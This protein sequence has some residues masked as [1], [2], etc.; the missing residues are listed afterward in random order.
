MTDT[1][2]GPVSPARLNYLVY[3]TLGG[4]LSRVPEPLAE[5]SASLVAEALAHLPAGSADMYARHLHRVLGRDL[6][7]AE[8]RTWTRRAYRAYARYWLEGARLGSLDRRVIERRMH[9]ES[10]WAQFVSAMDAGRGVILAL[11]HVGSWEWGGAW[12]ALKGY[13]MTAVAEP[14]EPPEL[15]DWF[16]HERE[17]M[18]LTIVQLGPDVGPVLLRTLRGGGLVGLL[19]DRDIQGNGIEVEFFGERTTLPA[20]PATLA[21]R[22][23]AALIPAAVYSG[24]G[25]GHTGVIGA[26]V[27]LE[28]TGRLRADVARITQDVAKALERLIRRAPEQWHLFQPNWPSDPGYGANFQAATEESP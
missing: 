11:P 16:V 28:R 2:A 8:L 9:V 22:T 13:P 10:G 23:G 4:V 12:L 25:S 18:G 14:I 7:R 20:G 3:R 19:C 21:L 17:K 6:S 26:P 15:Y 27:S 5:R 24:P 1:E